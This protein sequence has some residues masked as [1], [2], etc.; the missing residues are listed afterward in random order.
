MTQHNFTPEEVELAIDLF[1]A[2]V[3]QDTHM[4]LATAHNLSAM[5][6]HRNAVDV[7]IWSLDKVE[8]VDPMTDLPSHG[9]GS[10]PPDD[11]YV[12][13]MTTIPGSE[14]GRPSTA[15]RPLNAE[16]VIENGRAHNVAGVTKRGRPITKAGIQWGSEWVDPNN[17][18][19][20]KKGL[21]KE[22]SGWSGLNRNQ[23]AV[24]HLF[25]G[26]HGRYSIGYQAVKKVV[27]PT[28][29]LRKRKGE[30][31]PA[32]VRPR[33][34]LCTNSLINRGLLEEIADDVWIL[35][36]RGQTFVRSEYG[37]EPTPKHTTVEAVE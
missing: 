25:C 24:L 18:V 9:L 3:D 30:I 32:Q 21:E 33:P 35:T 15:H 2:G 23:H 14:P 5:G 7:T 12:T 29:D 28:G 34:R 20:P 8:Q 6:Y 16:V 4:L 37:M 31:N 19:P 11:D 27:K 17:T 13:I 26:E 10:A 22:W 36:P 1:K